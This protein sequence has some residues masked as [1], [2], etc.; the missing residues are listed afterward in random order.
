V[1]EISGAW[2]SRSLSCA[3]AS[4]SSALIAYFAFGD[5]MNADPENSPFM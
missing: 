4:T 5:S 2:T 1:L 3:R